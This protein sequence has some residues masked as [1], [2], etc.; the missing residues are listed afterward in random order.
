MPGSPLTDSVKPVLVVLAAGLARRYGG[1]KQLEP[2]GPCGEA[3][4][5][6]GIYDAVRAGFGSVVLV[7]RPE[8]EARFRRHVTD[9]VGD[10]VPVGYISQE[11]DDLPEGCKL[12]GGRQRPW[13]TGHAVLA[14]RP[15]VS[16]PFA[17][18]N[19]DDFYGASSYGQLAEHLERLERGESTHVLVGYPLHKTLSPF[20]G[21]SRCIVLRDEAGYVVQLTEIEGIRRVGGRIAG[22]TVQGERIDLT[23]DE[24]VSMNLWGFTPQVF[25]A[26]ER[27][28]FVFLG[29]C[30]SDSTAEFLLTTGLNEEIATGVL[31]IAVLEASDQWFG[32]TCPEERERVRQ[33]VA[34]LVGQGVYPNDLRE[35]FDEL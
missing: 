29:D 18:C 6:Y 22:T 30:V 25:I 20:G 23:N 15:A 3:L 24:L 2:V 11:L 26:L 33:A 14:A 21:V 7:V 35:G 17:V 34:D 10:A 4:L 9:T 13:G 19:A 1:L 32:M 5:D 12:P 27:Q 8:L 16:G 28:F 31:R